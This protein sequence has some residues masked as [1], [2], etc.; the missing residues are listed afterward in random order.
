MSEDCSV[1]FICSWPEIIIELPGGVRHL[2]HIKPH[3]SLYPNSQRDSFFKIIKKNCWF[4]ETNEKRNDW[5]DSVYC[6]LKMENVCM[7]PEAADF[8]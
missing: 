3:R 8:G 6:L 7:R 5:K 2:A 1:A 4:K